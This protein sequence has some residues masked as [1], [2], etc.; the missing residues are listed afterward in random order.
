MG[1]GISVQ[2]L[3][4]LEAGHWLRFRALRFGPSR[5]SDRRFIAASL[6]GWSSEFNLVALRALP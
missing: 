5:L 4:A 6:R 3:L 1:L 2:D